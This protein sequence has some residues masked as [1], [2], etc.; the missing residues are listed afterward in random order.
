[1]RKRTLLILLTVVLLAFAF[2]P[3]EGTFAFSAGRVAPGAGASVVARDAAYVGVVTYDVTATPGNPVTIARV[4]NN[5]QVP[6]TITA[7]VTS[8]PNGLSPTLSVSPGTPV[9]VGSYAT[10]DL[11]TS[12]TTAGD[13][14][15]QFRVDGDKP[16]TFHATV[17]NVPVTV[18]IN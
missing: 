4:Y 16:A 1:M 6:L 7:T 18:H 9:A 2:D 3:L 13:Y 17:K 15:F 5:G 10:I 12:Q 8:D 11:T 14:P